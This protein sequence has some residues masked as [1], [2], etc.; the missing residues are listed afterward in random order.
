MISNRKECFTFHCIISFYCIKSH[1]YRINS[2]I[3]QIYFFLLFNFYELCVIN[4]YWSKV[5]PFFVTN[6]IGSLKKSHFMLWKI[7]KK[8]KFCKKRPLYFV[9]EF[10]D[11][12]FL[13]AS[14][15]P[16]N[17][18]W[19]LKP[20]AETSPVLF[21]KK[22]S[23]YKTQTFYINMLRGEFNWKSYESE[24]SSSWKW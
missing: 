8:K 13:N 17:N 23:K 15:Y 10:I 11:Q 21:F 18:N 5:L 6:R 2:T 20:S 22:R 24:L 19:N 7:E 14:W 3:L 1:W 16:A 12:T 9:N 4:C